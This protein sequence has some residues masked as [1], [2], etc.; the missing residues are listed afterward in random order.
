MILEL[1]TKEQRH[2]GIYT[3][4]GGTKKSALQGTKF[5][6]NDLIVLHFVPFSLYA[7]VPQAFDFSR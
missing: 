5:L 4:Q 3:P 7:F 6:K 2:R 1:G